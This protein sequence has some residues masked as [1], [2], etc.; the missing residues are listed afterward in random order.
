MNKHKKRKGHV[1]MSKIKE[2]IRL[3]EK[4]LNTSQIFRTTLVSR[5][6]IREYI[7]RAK[8]KNLTH[9]Q[10]LTL[11][12][13][14]LLKLLDIKK[15]GRRN[16]NIALNYEHINQELL[17]PHVTVQ[18]LWEEYL[19]KFPEGFYSYS[20]FAANINIWNKSQVISMHQNYKA[21]EIAEI[22]YAGATIP[23][24]CPN[25]HL[26]L[27]NAQIFVGCLPASKYSFIYATKDQTTLSWIKSCEEMFIFFGG[28]PEAVKCDNATSLISKAQF[29]ESDI[30]QTFNFFAKHYNTSIFPT[31]V[32][33]PQDKAAVENA[34]GN[35]QRQ[36]LA[37]IR[38]CKFYSL[39]E[40]N[41]TL[42]KYNLEFC[43]KVM[44][45]Y[46]KSRL[47]LFTT[48]EQQFLAPLP[49]TKYK[50]TE[51][52]ETK[53]GVNYHVQVETNHYSVPYRFAHKT[54]QVRITYDTVEVYNNNQ[55][56]SQH[57]RS[58]TT[59]QAF[60]TK[61]E[62]MPN[63]HR[64]MADWT[65]EKFIAMAARI[66]VET[67]T[68]I[69]KILSQRIYPQI[70]YRSCLGVVS[71]ANTYSKEKLEA[72]CRI[73]NTYNFYGYKSIQSLIK[74]ESLEIK[75]ESGECGVCHENIRGEF[76]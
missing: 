10:A 66:G 30:Q 6:T 23:I 36:V 24:H 26:P 1:D 33:K 12:D 15:S 73:S 64:F 19:N 72:A 18:I 34:V 43:T 13:D 76:H 8:A 31:R 69:E 49:T 5:P 74:S 50:T 46:G 68:Q 60:I 9:Q 25:S 71:L 41:Q 28:V 11:P 20:Q 32:R 53:V 35:L 39:H 65:P 42:K 48:I 7:S 59:Q 61:Q 56:I 52:K 16:L 29:Y 47:E 57:L 54:V 22:D 58:S 63:H 55:L 21:G 2:I 3:S 37:R 38:D 4:G 51:F 75:Q 62:H 67:K 70:A 17:K 44:K 45:T 14:E 27:F 40:L